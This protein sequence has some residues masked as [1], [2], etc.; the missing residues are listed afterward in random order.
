MF[1]SLRRF[2]KHRVVPLVR[3]CSSSP[4]V[5][6]AFLKSKLE[7]DC[8]ASHVVVKDTSGGCGAFFSIY[9]VSPLFEG[10]PLLQQH[11]MVKEALKTQV[12]DVHGLS[13]TTRTPKAYEEDMNN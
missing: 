2:P 5:T 12:K 4:P 7:K 13:L 8:K 10:M 3:T 6:E 1:R 11:R 9:I